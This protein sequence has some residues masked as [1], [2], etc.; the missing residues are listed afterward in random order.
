MSAFR[1]LLATLRSNAQ[2]EREKGNYFER[3]VRVYL[4]H[5]P[6]YADL[7]GGKVWLW[8]DW[9]REWLRRG[10]ADPETDHGI[11]LVAETA[12]G[13]LH[14]IQAKFYSD[15]ATLTMGDFSTFIALSSQKHF[16]RSLIFLTATKATSHLR[17]ALTGQK[18]PVTLISSFDLE[19]SKIDWA[20][21]LPSNETVRLRNIKT[22]R[23]YQEKAINDA[24]RGLQSADRGKLIMACGT[25]KTFTALRLAERQAGRGGAVLFLVPSLNLLSQTLTEWTQ[26]AAIPLHSYAV[27]SDSEVGKK[28]ASDDDFE[29]LIHELQYPATTR[30]EMLSRAFASRHDGEHLSVIFSTYHSIDV[31]HRAQQNHGLPDFDLIVC[32]EAHRATGA[33]FDGQDE[34]AFVKVHDN[35]AIRGKKRIYMTAT[36]R[37]YGEKARTKADED[38]G[39]VLYSMDDEENFGKTLHTLT[40]SEA[41]HKGILCDY[42]VIVLTVSED[43]ISRSLQ[44]LLADAANSINVNDAAKIV[45]CWRALSKMDSQDDLVV[46]PKPMRRAVAF[47]QV[48]ELQK[49][50]RTRK[51]SS[52][53]I[54]AQFQAV[55]EE[56]RRELIA[57]EPESVDAISRLRCEAHHVD[58][59]MGATE[60]NEKLAWLKS[61][62]PEDTCR[63][64][65]NVRCLSEVV[66]VPALDAV[67]FLT[68]KNS[69][70]DV[71]QSVGRVMRRPPG[72]GKKLGYVILPVVIPS[73]V[74]PE[75]A[76]NDNKTYRVVWE[77]LQAL[78]SHDDRFEAMINRM[79]FDGQDKN[80]M[81]VIAVT[82][83]LKRKTKPGSDDEKRRKKRDQARKTNMLGNDAPKPKPEPEPEQIAFE[84]GEI[85]RAILAKVVQ[86]CGSRLYW[87]QWAS[88]IA[89]IAATHITRLQTILDDPRNVAEQAAFDAFLAGLRADINESVTRGE[90]VEMLAQHLITRPVFEALFEGYNFIQMNP[91]SRAMQGVLAVLERH[92]LEKEAETLTRMYESVQR[93]AQDTKTVAGKQ[94]LVVELYDKFF[95]NAFPKMAKRLGIAYTPVEVVD[96][97]LHSINDALQ[98][99]FGQTLGSRNV[100]I[101]D[102]FAGTG[103]FITRLLQSGL[104]APEELP[105]KYQNAIHANEIMLLAYYIA[106]INIEAV[107]HSI[108]GGEYQPF[109]GICLTDTFNLPTSE[110]DDLSTLGQENNSARLKRQRGLDIRVIMGN[111][112]YSAGQKSANDNNQNLVYPYLDKRITETYSVSSKATSTKNL[113]DS[114]IRAI[115]WASDR[116]RDR[117]VIGFVSNAGWLDS[118]SADGLRKCLAE[119]FCSIHVFHLRGN[120]RTSGERS[121]QEGG[122]IFG[123]GSRAPIAIYL[124]VKNPQA[125]E[126]GKILFHDIGDYL[127]REEKLARI[128]EFKSI[129]GIAAADGWMRIAPDAHHDW[130]RQR[131]SG[132]GEFIVLGDKKDKDKTTIFDTYSLGINSNRDAWVYNSSRKTVSTN[133]ENSIAFYNEEMKRYEIACSGKQKKRRPKVMDIVNTDKTRIAWPSSLVEDAGRF[134]LGAYCQKALVVSMYRPFQK[135]WLYYDEMFNHRV[136]QMPRIFPNSVIKNR[137]ITMTAKGAHSYSCLMSDSLVDLN[138]MNA[139]AQCFPEY[140]YEKNPENIEKY[141]DNFDD[142]GII[143][144]QHSTAQHSTAQ[145]STA[146]HPLPLNPRKNLVIC[147]SLSP[148]KGFSVLMTDTLPDLHLIG[149]A[150]C[151][152]MFLYDTEERQ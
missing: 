99:E 151:F 131:D 100:H 137:I 70:V 93:R 23:D 74:A 43:H 123:G 64:L 59:G 2:S 103:T 28:R 92:H 46:D 84:F 67:L 53:H 104:I 79:R 139:G 35:A 4:T 6:Y 24:L 21:Y 109:A 97:I 132:F 48:I 50:A 121:R 42:K 147:L 73:G 106:A 34:S 87:E 90:A 130:L 63:I 122:K 125:S 102:P 13:E 108:V 16:A 25:G 105:W 31:L 127:T 71:V 118:N 111:P 66:D 76:L 101:I 57:E 52:K 148:K 1:N 83:G 30:P 89:R 124:L 22:P 138:S 17:E 54:A 40:F 126:Q 8:E 150:Q 60:K 135:Q 15:D 26:E 98:S 144:A 56:Y 143:S 3:L 36:P 120:Q 39:V 69:Q 88:D 134:K 14:A 44:K 119:E 62:P 77:V 11:D 55:V 113:L 5:E 110:K 19:A 78:R 37:V 149:D 95:R 146:Q 7:Y 32:D 38:G 20:S 45:G 47:A 114:Y 141:L 129:A 152:P 136:G 75:E 10:N 117:G 51:I 27:C 61:E 142:P 18:T 58:G 96:F 133:M 86:K 80:R 94:R 72:G 107:Y 91:I 49:G 12:D 128:D 9:R 29:L 115:R 65:S 145:H 112:P 85:E 33:T 82:D 140:I 81:E 116:I 68:P 41:V